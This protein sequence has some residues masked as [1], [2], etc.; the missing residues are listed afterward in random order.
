VGAV[1]IL[2]SGPLLHPRET[3]M[4]RSPTEAERALLRARLWQDRARGA[5]IDG[6]GANREAALYGVS[7]GSESVT[8]TLP[9]DAK[10]PRRRA[11]RPRASNPLDK[12]RL[13]IPPME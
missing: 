3:R 13:K 5:M 11:R 6:D 12:G 9:P 1:V 7:A 10:T 2:P 8:N 4:P